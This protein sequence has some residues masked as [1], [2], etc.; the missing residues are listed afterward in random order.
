[1]K[2][3]NWFFTLPRILCFL[4]FVLELIERERVTSQVK[5]YF[6]NQTAF[7]RGISTADW[8]LIWADPEKKK[9]ISP[10]TLYICSKYSWK[11]PLLVQQT[12]D[13]KAK[14]TNLPPV[15]L[16]LSYSMAESYFAEIP[17]IVFSEAGQFE[18]PTTLSCVEN[19]TSL[20]QKLSDSYYR[21]MIAAKKTRSCLSS[22][23]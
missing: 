18:E 3:I 2:K 15:T 16:F 7:P 21:M 6:K 11:F 14:C 10:I 4:F 22:F 17:G 5:F 9:E 19:S 12:R 8:V 20:K 1:M 13:L 23:P